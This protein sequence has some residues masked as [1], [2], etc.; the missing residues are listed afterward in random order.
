MTRLERLQKYWVYGGFLAGLMLLALAPLLL[1]GWDRAS[2]LAFL[3]LP[4]YMLHQYEEHDDDRFH[5]F[6]VAELGH[7]R[8]VLPTP[9][10]FLINMGGV[11]ALMVAVI[12][13]M[14]GVNPGFGVVAG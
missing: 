8:D 13:L 11:W 12:W 4:V 10:I 5:R 2:I 6:V 1:S 9:A 3:V 14:R 7:G